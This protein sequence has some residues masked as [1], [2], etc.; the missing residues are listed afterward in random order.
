MRVKYLLL[1]C[2]LSLAVVFSGCTRN[3]QAEV[4]PKKQHT[5]PVEDSSDQASDDT[6]ER[7]HTLGAGNVA[8]DAKDATED[9]EKQN[10]DA[11]DQSN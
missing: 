10:S 5:K 6:R 2:F 7:D 8:T 3:D 9:Q 11:M 4:K 1:L